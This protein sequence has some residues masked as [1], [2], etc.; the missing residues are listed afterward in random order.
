MISSKNG[1]AMISRPVFLSDR[2]DEVF[3]RKLDLSVSSSSSSSSSLLQQFNK[4]H[5]GSHLSPA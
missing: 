3:S 2:V 1:A 4:T 5:E